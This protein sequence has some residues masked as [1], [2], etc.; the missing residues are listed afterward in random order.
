MNMV[1]SLDLT[2]VFPDSSIISQLQAYV[3]KWNISEITITCPILH[4]VRSQ[5]EQQEQFLRTEI[6]GEGITHCDHLKNL[7]NYTHVH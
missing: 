6:F 4:A 5:L 7:Q 1:S 3:P 2:P